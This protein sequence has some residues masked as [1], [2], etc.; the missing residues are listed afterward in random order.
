MHKDEF[1]TNLFFSEMYQCNR[2]L[3]KRILIY[4]FLTFLVIVKCVYCGYVYLKQFLDNPVPYRPF[5]FAICLTYRL[6]SGFVHAAV[7]EKLN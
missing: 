5:F 7:R 6:N 3:Q 2:I 1:Y 4:I